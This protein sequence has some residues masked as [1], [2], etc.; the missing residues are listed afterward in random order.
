MET[1]RTRIH[2]RGGDGGGGG[3]GGGEF[4]NRGE[5]PILQLTYC[6]VGYD[7]SDGNYGYYE[8]FD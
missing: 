6:H 4:E 8:L 3:G 7:P 1:D 2:S 5:R